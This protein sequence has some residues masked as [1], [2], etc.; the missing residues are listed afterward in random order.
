MT[1]LE[2]KFDFVKTSDMQQ[3]KVLIVEDEEIIGLHLS[4]LITKLG[5]SVVAISNNGASAL[6]N[7]DKHQPDIMLVDIGLKGDMNGIEL[8]SKIKEIEDLPVIY[9]SSDS[10]E[11]NLRKAQD[12]FP[13]AFL[14]KPFDE[15]QIATTLKFSLVRFNRQKELYEK[16]LRR[17]DS[18][19]INIKELSE[20]N[21]HLITATWRERDLKQELQK[22][23]AIIETQNK[24]ILDSINY[25]KRIQG[26]IAPDKEKLCETLQKHFLFY[27]PKD[28]VS[29]DFPWLYV[30]ENHIYF[31]AVD[32]TGH[33]VPG[34]MMS[35]IGNLLLNDVVNNEVK[36]KTPS[37]VLTMLH[38]GVVKTLK[39]DAPGNKAADGMDIA[40][41]RLRNDRKELLFSGAHLPLFHFSKKNGLVTYKG[42]RFPVGGVQHRNKNVY[43][44]HK[45]EIQNGDKI[46]IFSDGIIDQLGGAD[47]RKW[48]TVG[49]QQFI[50]DN[51]NLEMP[52]FGKKI[53]Q[54]F[55]KY[56]GSNKQVDDVIL[57]GIEI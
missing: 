6:E 15:H 56:M 45:V 10:G 12:T 23:K 53:D 38:Q 40:L 20:T 2:T 55:T 28:V 49:L 17:T 57:F 41:C 42:S 11:E 16:L 19:E 37:E 52:E 13:N 22:T 35:M 43:E 36:I 24:K 8:V 3:T 7:Y 26:S 47:N 48:M 14:K 34:A 1:L 44:D 39:Q 29:G 51:A 25:A 9:L 31:G 30:R 18:Q 54:E 27:K 33:G 21:A 32:C 5:Y 50:I 4:K 46:F